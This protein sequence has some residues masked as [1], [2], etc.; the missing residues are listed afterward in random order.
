MSINKTGGL[1]IACLIITGCASNP[2]TET[3][4]TVTKTKPAYQPSTYSPNFTKVSLAH[5]IRKKPKIITPVKSGK[6]G[7]AKAIKPK[8]LFIKT[9]FNPLKAQKHTNL[10]DWMHIFGQ[11][12][13]R[14]QKLK[15]RKYTSIESL[16]KQT[17]QQFNRLKNIRGR[18]YVMNTMS[19]RIK[20]NI[21][22]DNSDLVVVYVNDKGSPGEL[23][24]KQVS[25]D[26]IE[27]CVVKK[28]RGGIKRTSY[29]KFFAVP[30]GIKTTQCR[31]SLSI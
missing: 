2:P 30:K 21:N 17:A 20:Q 12:D 7:K 31:T 23:V 5:S 16:E 28:R 4:T 13:N 14:I 18:S 11:G 29:K 24:K 1:C 9:G 27:F 26:T 6:N 22:F 8:E 3:K 15:V 25:P 19:K 10:T